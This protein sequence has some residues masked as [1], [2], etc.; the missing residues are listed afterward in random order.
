MKYSALTLDTNIVKSNAFKF[1]EGL[2]AKLAQFNK[3]HIQFVLSEVVL[4]EIKKHLGEDLKKAKNA[5]DSALQN[6]K[7]KGLIS[8]SSYNEMSSLLTSE[9]GAEDLVETK[10][11]LFM[12]VTG[13]LEVSA[14]LANMDDLI[15]SYFKH[16]CPFEE[17]GEKRKEFPDAIALLSLQAWA[18]ENDKYILAVSNDNGWLNYESANNRISFKNDLAAALDDIL[19]QSTQEDLI[20]VLLGKVRTNLNS[21]SE[22]DDLKEVLK[23]SLE[24]HLSRL[25]PYVEYCNSTFIIRDEWSPEIILKNVEID[26]E[27]FNIVGI[28]PETVFVQFYVEATIDFIQDFSFYMWDSVDK[29]ELPCGS[30]QVT[31]EERVDFQLLVPFIYTEEALESDL[32][33]DED[34]GIEVIG[35]LPLVD[36]G[37]VEI[38][39]D[40]YH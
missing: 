23:E 33:Y 24:N 2:L 36:F 8:E 10:I 12:N 38:G 32:V 16:K 5:L 7:Q 34:E 31:L 15:Q 26:R 22:Y 35:E 4:R 14:N 30:R 6:S 25:E 11:A 29:E 19:E 37:E 13:G 39:D 3:S 20:R 40:F 27:N 9:P 28:Q 21:T 17:K 1:E 18:E